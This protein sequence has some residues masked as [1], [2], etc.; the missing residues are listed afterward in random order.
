MHFTPVLALAGLAAAAP[1][2]NNTL[3]ARGYNSTL[4]TL[5]A[6]NE[7][8]LPVPPPA[9]PP[10]AGP[11]AGLPAGLKYRRG[12]TYSNATMS[13][14]VTNLSVEEKLVGNTL[15]V[16]SIVSVY[17]NLNSNI[18]CTA[19]NP[20]TDGAVFPCGST[21]YSFGLLEGTSTDFALALY[22]AADASTTHTGKADVPT[23]CHA[24]GSSTAGSYEVC[25]QVSPS[26]DISL[27]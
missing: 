8:G 11:P 2:S 27:E 23:T 14:E 26:T 6:R 25:Y 9:G 13:A 17:F 24:G 22:H 12:Q 20:G 7:T 4:P 5:V 3:L 18:T 1:Y 21:P 10:P 16:E 15:N 19:E